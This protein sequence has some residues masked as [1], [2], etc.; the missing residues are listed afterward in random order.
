MYYQNQYDISTPVITSLFK[1]YGKEVMLKEIQ[2]LGAKRVFLTRSIYH[3][4]KESF[5]KEIE[6]IRDVCAFLKE[7]GYEVGL[8][9]WSFMVNNLKD[10]FQHICN[11]D[12]AVDKVSACPLDPK[13]REFA[14][15][16][17][18]ELAKTGVDILLYDDDYRLAHWKSSMA[19]GCDVHM[20]RIH[21][22]VGEDISAVDFKKKM[23]S[24]GKNKYRDA[25]I[26][27]NREALT[28]FAAHIRKCVDEVN[29]NVRIGVCSCMN[30]DFDGTDP[31]EI[32]RIMAGN[33]KPFLRLIGA[34]YWPTQPKWS[35]F[36]RLGT[37]IELERMELNWCREHDIEIIAEGDTYPRPRFAVPASYLELF[38]IAMM[39][40]GGTNGILNYALDYAADPSYETAY[41]DTVCRNR[42]LYGEIRK[43]FAPKTACGMR[44]VEKQKRFADMEIPEDQSGSEIVL[45][46]FFS[47]AAKMTTS[48]GIPSTYASSDECSII[49]GENARG[50]S[51]DLL[52][53]GAIL[54]ITAARILQEAGVDT[55]IVSVGKKVRPSLERFLDGDVDVLARYAGFVTELAENAKPESYFVYSDNGKSKRAPASYL[56]ENANGQKFLVFTFDMYHNDESCYRTYTRGTQLIKACEKLSGKPLP[57]SVEKCPDMYMMCKRDDG[58]LAVGLWNI[59]SDKVREPVVTLEKAYKDIHFVKGSGRLE[60][61]KVYLD[62]IPA[63]EFVGFEVK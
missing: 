59:F 4:N 53:N 21:E 18:A 9:G 28:G 6:D 32:S 12:G 11:F 51:T 36:N 13:F 22:M 57:A 40:D 44:I 50:I 16:Y 58:K 8:W 26:A 33:T 1:R 38:D 34:T 60:G 15:K 49:F 25:Y 2:R 63:F 47:P 37:V 46:T 45:D 55:G 29:P 31:A 27:A 62:E 54:D 43:V 5:E 42:E 7:H 14:G 48:L 41:V 17:A 10:E 20:N 30:W 35:I 24:G 61:N 19:C 23:L 39:A 3:L 56:Y 52:N